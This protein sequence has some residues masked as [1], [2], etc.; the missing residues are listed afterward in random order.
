MSL[1]AWWRRGV[2][3]LGGRPE[4]AAC[5]ACQAASGQLALLGQGHAPF[6]SPAVDSRW[7]R[8][9]LPG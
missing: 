4:L 6:D 9:L 5:A 3:R 2:L 7:G 1:S 8:A